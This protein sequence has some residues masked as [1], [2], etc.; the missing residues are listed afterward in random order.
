MSKR[1]FLV[2]LLFSLAQVNL[3]AQKSLK[4]WIVRHAEKDTSDVKDKDPDLSMQ[5]KQRAEALM[6]L[7]KGQ[8]IDS[9]FSTN[10]KRTKLTGFPLA[11]KIGITIKTYSP[12]QK[13][14][15][16]KNLKMNAAGKHILIVGH[17]NTILELIEAFGAQRPLAQIKDDEYGYIFL[18]TIKGD[19]VDVKV[20]K[21]GAK[22][23]VE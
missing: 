9:I 15:L 10:Y 14:E 2:F 13:A 7:L 21:Y 12:S 16:V 6:K 19:K 5:G 8:K 3:Q 22:V 11:D 20:D 23:G 1:I 18:L 17:S 4:V